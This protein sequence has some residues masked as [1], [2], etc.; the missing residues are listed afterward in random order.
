EN[1][2]RV[3]AEDR[4]HRGGRERDEEREPQRELRFPRSEGVAESAGA[5]FEGKD[6]DRAER[7]EDQGKENG[8]EDADL[9]DRIAAATRGGGGGAHL[10]IRSITRFFQ[11]PSTISGFARSHPP[12]SAIV[13]GS[14]IFPKAGL[15]FRPSSTLRNPCSTKIFCAF[16]VQRK[17]VRFS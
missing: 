14:S 3:R 10:T 1:V 9:H 6:E 16:S 8:D 17:R 4:V 7:H 5:S 2:G 11:I 12:K 15:T 13:K